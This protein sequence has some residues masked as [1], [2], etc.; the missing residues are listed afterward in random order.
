MTPEESIH[1]DEIRQ[2][3]F[4]KCADF[5]DEMIRYLEHYK[6]KHLIHEK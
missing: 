2:A 3:Y 4:E 1:I 5:K 6:P